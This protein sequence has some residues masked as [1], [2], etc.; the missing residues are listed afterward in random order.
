MAVSIL[1]VAR[2]KFYADGGDLLPVKWPN[3]RGKADS[4]QR[5]LER[6]KVDLPGNGGNDGRTNLL[7]LHL[8]SQ[9]RKR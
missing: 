5:V 8:S 7:L 3:R 6:Y 4:F 1:C 2:F 9:D